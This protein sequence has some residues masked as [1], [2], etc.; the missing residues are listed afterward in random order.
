MIDSAFLSF[1]VE[2]GDNLGTVFY[3]LFLATQ[4][5]NTE[6]VQI[7]LTT[8][9]TSWVTVNITAPSFLTAVRVKKG[10]ALIVSLPASVRSS[11]P[12]RANKTVRISASDEVSVSALNRGSCANFLVLP[13]KMLGDTY[14]VMTWMATSGLAQVSVLAVEDDTV[15]HVTVSGPDVV[16]VEYE[17]TVY[18]KGDVLT[19]T[20][21]QYESLILQSAEDL[22]GTFVVASKPV[23]L[24]AGNT[25]TTI[26]GG[27]LKDQLV[28]QFTPVNTWGYRFALVPFPATTSGYYVKCLAQD[29][30]TVVTIITGG[31]ENSWT[32]S[33]GE[34]FVKDVV[35]SE[36]AWI[37]SNNQILVVQYSKSQTSPTD[38]SAPASLL[39]PPVVQYMSD[40]IF[41]VPA[42]TS[43]Y[44]LIVIEKIHLNGIYLDGLP[45][46]ASSGWRDIE[47]S[48]PLMSTR[49]IAIVEGAHR[50]RHRV[51]NQTFGAYIYGFTPSDCA[52]ANPAGMSLLKVNKVG[53]CIDLANLWENYAP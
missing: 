24:Y 44:A 22:T 18:D 21:T 29:S 43:I 42:A 48:S 10:E 33:K 8:P 35:S 19:V 32:L 5:D 30:G 39:I 3:L 47:G 27:S 36:T 52:Y 31:A 41:T 45:V 6:D 50:L 28:S 51:S 12:G 2:R 9:S 20:L 13:L 7:S 23:A 15:V 14:Y 11:E 17:G 49:H 40:Y 46:N 53:F 1:T 26:G 16:T 38:L 25:E 4:P 37:E 34:F